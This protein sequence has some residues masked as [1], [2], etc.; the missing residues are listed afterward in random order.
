MPL[1]TAELCTLLITVL[2]NKRIVSIR[3]T[4]TAFQ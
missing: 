1:L 4:C 2:T 3:Q